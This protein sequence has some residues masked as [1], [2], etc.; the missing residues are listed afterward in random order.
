MLFSR[1]PHEIQPKSW[2][3]SAQIC[4][5]QLPWYLVQASRHLQD[6][7]PVRLCQE[8]KRFGGMWSCI[9]AKMESAC[10]CATR[11]DSFT[12]MAES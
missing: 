1:K 9:P 7:P 10:Q 3:D 4:F 11:L 8:K 5:E 12:T 6:M 2:G